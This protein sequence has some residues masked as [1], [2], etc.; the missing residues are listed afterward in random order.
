MNAVADHYA[1]LL[2]PVYLWMAGGPEAALSQGE[3]ELI[4]LNLPQHVSG[5]KAL[6]LGAGF[7]MHSIP[8]AHRGYDVTAIDSSALLLSQLQQLGDD[9]RIRTIESDLLEFPAHLDGPPSLVLCMGDTLTH[10]SNTSEVVRLCS[11]IARHLK[12]GGRVVT[13]FRDYTRPARGDA[14]FI[15]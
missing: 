8:L 15:P 4:A 5:A 12:P 3:A 9:L 7:G 10:L 6:D 11:L 1:R 2:A 13:T 14:R